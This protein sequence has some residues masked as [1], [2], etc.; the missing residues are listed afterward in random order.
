[1][2]FFFIRKRTKKNHLKQNRPASWDDFVCD[3]RKI[4]ISQKAKNIPYSTKTDSK[5]KIISF[6]AL[7]LTEE[8]IPSQFLP[9]GDHCLQVKIKN[10]QGKLD[11]SSVKKVQIVKWK[12]PHYDPRYP[13]H[14]MD[15]QAEL[16]H[17]SRFLIRATG[18]LKEYPDKSCQSA[19]S[20]GTGNRRI[21]KADAAFP[22]APQVKHHIDEIIV[23]LSEQNKYPSPWPFPI[24]ATLF[25]YIGE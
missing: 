1:M 3:F 18:I 5:V 16:M 12:I 11:S 21:S 7:I 4:S 2:F 10:C 20:D 14:V 13:Y 22:D 8:I 24:Q 15:Y 25:R 6:P 23:R 9:I 19:G 17:G